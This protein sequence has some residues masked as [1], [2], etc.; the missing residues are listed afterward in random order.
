MSAPRRP[1]LPTEDRK[2]LRGLAERAE[3]HRTETGTDQAYAQG[4]ADVL[5]WIVGDDYD[6]AELLEQ[7]T[8]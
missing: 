5:R 8:R 1:L 3:R 7:V 4:V 6:P 2:R